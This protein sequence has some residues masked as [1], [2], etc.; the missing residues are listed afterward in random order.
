MLHT[1]NFLNRFK[2]NKTTLLTIADS[3]DPSHWTACREQLFC[4]VS[5]GTISS[6]L[7]L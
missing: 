5:A 7:M 6:L 3:N 1:T 2:K 4:S